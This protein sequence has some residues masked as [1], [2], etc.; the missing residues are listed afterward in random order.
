MQL[1]LLRSGRAEI[2]PTVDPAARRPQSGD[3]EFGA[4]RA[5]HGLKSIQFADI[6][7]R[8]HDVNLEWPKSRGG[9]AIHGAPGKTIAA[10]PANRIVRLRRRA[11]E[12]DLNVQI[13]E[14]GA[15]PRRFVSQKRAIG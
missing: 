11:V 15:T 13:I 10:L 12:A 8:R 3:P 6:A 14:R 5:R 7:A 2:V 1:T 4:I 9:Q